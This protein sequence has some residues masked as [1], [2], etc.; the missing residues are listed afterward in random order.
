MITDKCPNCGTTNPAE[1]SDKDFT[2]CTWYYFK[3][4][5]CQHEW[6]IKEIRA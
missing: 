1:D 2:G 5:E 3:C 4:E 6:S